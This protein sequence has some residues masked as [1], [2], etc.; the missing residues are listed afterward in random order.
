MH[1]KV[2]KSTNNGTKLDFPVFS[3][4]L[5][6]E[7]PFGNGLEFW[8]HKIVLLSFISLNVHLSFY[9]SL[10]LASSLTNPKSQMFKF[11]FGVHSGGEIDVS[12]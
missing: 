7:A 10:Q 1:A 12:L 3:L 8:T 9:L 2:F 11:K 6:L 4:D 5:S